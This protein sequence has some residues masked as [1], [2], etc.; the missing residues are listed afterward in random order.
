MTQIDNLKTFQQKEDT[1]EL[2]ENLTKKFALSLLEKINSESFD[3]RTK[4]SRLLCVFSKL[5]IKNHFDLITEEALDLI[6]EEALLTL[7]SQK[8]F[9]S[10]LNINKEIIF[11]TSDFEKNSLDL[12]YVALSKLENWV[13]D[14]RKKNKENNWDDLSEIILNYLSELNF[15]TDDTYL[16]ETDSSDKNKVI[17]SDQKEVKYLPLINLRRRVKESKII[18]QIRV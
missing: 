4:Y 2:V 10:S 13:T 14:R 9:D 17:A 11:I 6:K 3:D 5:R 18:N 15:D 8:N 12:Q 1:S 16:I 7:L